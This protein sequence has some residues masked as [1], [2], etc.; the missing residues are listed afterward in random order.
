MAGEAS[1]NCI[2][3]RIEVQDRA[4]S[5]RF[6]R[7]VKDQRLRRTYEVTG[8]PTNC[9]R[10][11]TENEALFTIT[12]TTAS[13]LPLTVSYAIADGTALAGSDYVATSGTFGGHRMSVVL[14]PAG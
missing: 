9:P 11:G 8:Q 10:F 1:C 6:L 12:N 13:A 14:A 7:T 4:D 5:S 2:A 3:N